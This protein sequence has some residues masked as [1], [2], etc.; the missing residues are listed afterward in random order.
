MHT[1]APAKAALPAGAVLRFC[2]SW[3]APFV[4]MEKQQRQ[5]NTYAIV[6]IAAALLSQ[7]PT[8]VP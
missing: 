8:R 4:V 2:T 3:S 5:R 1:A 7:Q 6:W